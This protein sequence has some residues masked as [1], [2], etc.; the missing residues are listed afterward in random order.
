VPDLFGASGTAYSGN[1]SAY[2]AA[3]GSGPA[4]KTCRDCEH[5][6]GWTNRRGN[7]TYWKC[8]LVK[9]TSGPGT[10]IRVRTPACSRF[11]PKEG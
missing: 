7:K 11:K 2:A 9:H 1:P 3:P 8:G 6:E 10:D 5:A 4:G